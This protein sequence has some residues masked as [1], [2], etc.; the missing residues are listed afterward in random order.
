MSDRD[1][2]SS[3]NGFEIA[4]IGM[5][6]RFPGAP[7][8]D[9]FWE[10]L[11]NGV[12]SISRFSEQEMLEAGVDPAILKSPDYVRAGGVIEDVDLFDATF[13]NCS[14]REAR[15]MDP[16]QRLFLESAYQALQ[17]AGCD[18]QRYPHAIGVFAGVGASTYTKLGGS[19][20]DTGFDG[21]QTYLGNDRNF[22]STRVSYKLN[23]RG[24]SIW[25]IKVCSA[26]N[27]MSRWLAVWPSAFRKNRDISTS[28]KAFSLRTDIAVLSTRLPKARLAERVLASWC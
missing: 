11:C 24:P 3:E 10:N 18:P 20:S 16:Q 23:L 13:F 21:M 12:E 26:V 9:R 7:D 14:Q 2:A 15:I 22:L 28:A 4:V 17:N 5:A 1:S 6:G 19:E 8:T 27:A 25:R